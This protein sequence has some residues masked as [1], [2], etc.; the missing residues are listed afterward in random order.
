MADKI[1]YQ[2]V[3]ENDAGIHG[4][5]K[6]ISGGDLSVLTGNPVQHEPGTNPEQLIGLALAT[7][8]NATIEAEE[9]RRGL[10]HQSVV[11]VGITMGFDDPGFQFWLDAQVKIPEVS[12]D[13]GEKILQK[14]ETRCPV[15]KLLQG[16]QN[17]TVHLVD[18]FDFSE[19]KA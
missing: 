2:T 14:A 17:V 13:E 3:V 7:C 5:A 10:S 16:N 6:V 19:K 9:K 12:A 15:A 1:L 8:L 4:Q 11:R 18:D